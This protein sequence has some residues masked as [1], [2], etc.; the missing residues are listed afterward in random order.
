VP[1][2]AAAGLASLNLALIYAWLPE[3]LTDAQGAQPQA[4]R[5]APFSLTALVDTLRRPYTGALLITRF[6][7][8]VA[9][10][11]FQTI[12]A[13]YA[14]RRFGLTAQSTGFVLT[15]VGVLVVLVQGYL[16][17]QLTDRFRDDLLIALAV[18]VMAVALL[19]WAWAP[20]VAW[21]LV[22]LIPIAASG[23]LLNTL[24]ASTLTR[25]ARPDEVG[26]LL[27]LVTALDS[28]ARIVAPSL[29]GVLI[30]QL[31]TA[32]PGLFGAAVMAGV[33]VFG[34]ADNPEP[35]PCAPDG[36]G[37]EDARPAIWR[38]GGIGGAGWMP[39]M[40]GGPAKGALCD[41][42]GPESGRWLQIVCK[43]LKRTE[44]PCRLVSASPGGFWPHW[45]WP[46]ESGRSLSQSLL[47][48]TPCRL[49][50]WR[51]RIAA[52]SPSTA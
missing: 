7:F 34:L 37:G 51:I 31:G 11:M 36:P 22:I 27:G 5:R 12:F 14:L 13:L 45:G 4:A 9:F 3:S 40:V 24:I 44:R 1:A 32:G 18:P 19:G 20:S 48:R 43:T 41:R 10:S 42:D 35:S 25:A 6:L 2:F 28:A 33:S 30:Q 17:G 38:L 49:R 23:G 50:S 26:G 39:Q 21:L 29:G 16:V 15:Y 8:S 52:S 47:S 46:W